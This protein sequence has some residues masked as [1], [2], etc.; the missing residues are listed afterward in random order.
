MIEFAVNDYITL[1][2]E[3]GVTNV[4]VEEELYQQ[5]SYLL[6]NVPIKEIRKF[7]DIKS[8]DEATEMLGGTQK[9]QEGIVYKIE[10]KTEFW[11]HCSNL[12]AWYEHNYDT[13][14]LHSNLAFPL[15]K[16]L[17]EVGDPIAKKVFKTEIVER[18]ESGSISVF[19]YLCEEGYL[20]YLEEDELSS[21]G[22][23]FVRKLL[24]KFL[25]ID[26]ELENLDFYELLNKAGNTIIEPIKD[27][28]AEKLHNNDFIYEL[29]EYD[30]IQSL[31]DDVIVAI[32]WDEET[33]FLEKTLDLAIEQNLIDNA[34]E[35]LQIIEKIDGRSYKILPKFIELPLSEIEERFFRFL[36]SLTNEQIEHFL[37]SSKVIEYMFTSDRW[38]FSGLGEDPLSFFQKKAFSSL[39]KIF[40]EI[41]LEHNQK[42]IEIISKIVYNYHFHYFWENGI[43]EI[44]DWIIILENTDHNFFNTLGKVVKSLNKE[45]GK[46]SWV[47]DSM[48]TFFR[49]LIKTAISPLIK[50]KII[51]SFVKK[52]VD[53]IIFMEVLLPW[54]ADPVFTD[55]EIK[56]LIIG[57][58]KST[59]IAHGQYSSNYMDRL[60]SEVI[61]ANIEAYENDLYEMLGNSSEKTSIYRFLK[62]QHLLVSLDY[63]KLI[64][65]S[66]NNDNLKSHLE[67]FNY[68][69]MLEKELDHPLTDCSERNVDVYDSRYIYRTT[70]DRITHLYLNNCDLDDHQLEKIIEILKNLS[71]LEDLRLGSNNITRVPDS[72]S[73]LSSIKSISLSNNQITH[74]PSSIE[75]LPLEGL[76]LHKNR[77]ESL[78]DSIGNLKS[79]KGLRLFENKLKTIPESI[80]NLNSLIWLSLSDNKIQTLPE[81]IGN[82]SSLENLNIAKNLIRKL[83]NSIL[84]LPKLK[85]LVVVDNPL[86]EIEEFI[87][88]KLKAKNVDVYEKF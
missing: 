64:K 30:F 7:D 45:Y 73:K 59:L 75:K 82:L 12:Q 58:L 21:L 88:S 9:G 48:G 57:S 61:K 66:E 25:S 52:D 5:C 3:Q 72:I 49:D 15:L 79:L 62:N 70:N 35:F 85:T 8:I 14:V 19:T 46:L 56:K 33:N 54:I 39:K 16:K 84:K 40:I 86:L 81:S 74:I 24:E 41:F 1:K 38:L 63:E 76:W 36:K 83:P 37:E 20:S 50:E 65:I 17:T 26:Y 78:P 2:L 22:E 27:M 55:A 68:I 69:P 87:L 23:E 67:D 43:M 29:I 71:L 77:L 6:I 51:E 10:P 34:H 60:I 42:S 11:G 44:K 80:G 13:R 47:N 32:F 18:L 4:Y 31:S 28:I 53:A